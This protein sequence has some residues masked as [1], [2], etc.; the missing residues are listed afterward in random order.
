MVER[1]PTALRRYDDAEVRRLL[2]RAAE[3]Q[4]GGGLAGRA[5]GLTLPEL[6]AAAAEAGLDVAALRQAAAELDAQPGRGAAA[7]AAFAGA[8]MTIRLERVL[9]FEVPTTAFDGLLPIIQSA[10]PLRFQVSQ[11]G[12]TL[13]WSANEPESSRRVEVIV[14]VHDGQ[15][16][17]VIEERL[18]AIAAGIF[19]GFM[20]G[21]GGASAGL[22]AALASTTGLALLPALMPV[23]V[24]GGTYAA[25]R[26]G[27][28][29]LARRRA[30][31]LAR[32]LEALAQQLLRSEPSH[33]REP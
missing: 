33:A 22:F 13:T 6:E 1:E 7:A 12:R 21:F 3:L 15:T 11:V 31:T 27:F 5:G 23:A 8:P 10:L 16:R 2:A 32:L 30:R 26:Y 29:G 19:G 14:S 17:V 18:G 24:L 9:P 28:R 4:E 20:G 25:C